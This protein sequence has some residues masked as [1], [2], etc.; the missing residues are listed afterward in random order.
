MQSNR[1]IFDPN[2]PFS[3]DGFVKLPKVKSVKVMK[4]CNDTM[5]FILTLRSALPQ[6]LLP[7]NTNYHK[8][9][10]NTIVDDYHKPGHGTSY[11]ETRFIEDKW[12]K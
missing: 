11:T 5:K 12:P 10:S 6:V 3:N 4:I 7:H 2:A 1:W 9:G 8:T